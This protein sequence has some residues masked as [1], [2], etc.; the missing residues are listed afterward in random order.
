MSIA[1]A[2]AINRI[3]SVPQRLSRFQGVLNSR[4][5]FLFA[6]ERLETLAFEIEDVLLAHERA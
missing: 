4:L 1:M 3:S 6:A 5:S 2:K